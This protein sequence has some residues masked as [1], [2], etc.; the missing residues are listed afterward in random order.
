MFLNCTYKCVFFFYCTPEYHPFL[1][2]HTQG[3]KKKGPNIVYNYSLNTIPCPQMQE[4]VSCELCS[5]FYSFSE[6]LSTSNKNQR[7]ILYSYKNS[8]Y[9]TLTSIFVKRHIVHS[10]NIIQTKTANMKKKQ[11]SV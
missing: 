11:T 1:H 5:L 9:T 2:V 3:T 7:L 4:G 8:V 10:I 6:I